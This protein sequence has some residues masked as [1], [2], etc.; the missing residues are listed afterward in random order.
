MPA[1]HEV[2]GTPLKGPFPDGV[3][4]AIFGMG[5]FWGAERIFWQSARRLHDRR[6]L[7]GRLHA[8]PDLRGGL[9]RPHRP[10]RGRPRR[11]RAATGRLR[12]HAEAVLGGP[13]PDAGHA[14][15][16]RRR[17]PVPLGDLLARRCA[18]RKPPRPR[19]PLPGDALAG[20][21]RRD[22]DRDRRARARSTT[23]RTTTSS[24][25]RRTPAATAASAAPASAARSERE[26]PPATAPRVLGV[27]RRA[28]QRRA[29]RLARVAVLQGGR[30]P[31]WSMTPSPHGAE[32]AG[33]SPDIAER[34]QRADG[35]SRSR[36][37]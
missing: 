14:P 15:G 9:Q 6:R 34:A 17:H 16:Q 32:S 19:A 12:G 13:R 7:C 11:L 3:E 27:Y 4:V 26:S 5:C 28:A 20:G 2:L 36:S 31:S 10:R 23:P 30:S 29:E 25:S 22:H 37:S 1:R 24:T 33:A 18:A 21:L 8:E 35:R